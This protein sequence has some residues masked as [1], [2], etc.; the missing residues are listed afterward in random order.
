LNLDLN[1]QHRK[2]PCG[3]KFGNFLEQSLGIMELPYD[4]NLVHLVL[5][6]VLTSDLFIEIPED[7]FL[8]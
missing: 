1:C 6:G 5:E 8:K 4:I 2:R 7:F 3:G